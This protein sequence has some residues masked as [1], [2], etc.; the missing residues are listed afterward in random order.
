VSATKA[1]DL[2]VIGLIAAMLS[3]LLV[4]QFYGDLPPLQWYLP[5][6][7]AALGVAEI[8]VA[9]GLRGRIRGDAGLRAADVLNA[10]RALALAKASAVA[11]AAFAGLWLGFLSYTVPNLGFLAAAGSDAVT[12]VVG[13]LSA[14]LLVTGALVLE[15]ACRTPLPPEDRNDR[16][17]RNDGS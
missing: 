3:W 12:G 11:G 1:R 2:C 9:Q 14:G 17:D 4:T 10:A 13:V 15:N 5:L 6:S 16:S 7:L 8:V